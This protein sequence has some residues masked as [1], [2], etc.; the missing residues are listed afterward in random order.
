MLLDMTRIAAMCA[1]TCVLASLTA[2]QS[3]KELEMRFRGEMQRLDA[4]SP[5]R[6]EQDAL[7]NRHVG[8]L[9]TFIKDKAK[10]DDES[11]PIDE[12]FCTA[13]EYGLPPTAGEGIGIDRLVMLLTNR[14]SIRDVILFP[15]LRR[16][17]AA[18]P[19]APTSES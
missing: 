15:T 10:G 1:F 14:H 5:T 17:G 8:E 3:L 7:F 12:S 11:M 13:L 4:K 2:Q 6:Q 16:Q 9:R 18:A 19:V